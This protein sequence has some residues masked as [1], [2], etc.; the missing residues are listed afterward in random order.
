[1]KRRVMVVEDDL[2]IR[3]TIGELLQAEGHIV[4]LACHGADALAQL[5][6]AD[7][8]PDVIFLDL[9]MPVKDGLEF[10]AEQRACPRLAGIPVVV[11][12]ADTRIDTH[13]AELAARS[14][15]RKPFDI[16]TLVAAAA[17]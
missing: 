4:M 10:R 15:I 9:M 8:L 5:Q 6:A 2:D 17:E 7:V 16:A 12:S 11:M 1:V 3:E 14:Y 13:R